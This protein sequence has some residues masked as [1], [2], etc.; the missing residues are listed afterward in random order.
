MEDQ[1]LKFNPKNT[2][3]SFFPKTYIIKNNLIN[4]LNLKRNFDHF[5]RHFNKTFSHYDFLGNYSTCSTFFNATLSKCIDPE[6]P[7]THHLLDFQGGRQLE[8]FRSSHLVFQICGFS[9]IDDRV[10]PI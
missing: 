9:I 5:R 6:S 4:L 10:S 2:F 1:N 3:N 8:S 7:S